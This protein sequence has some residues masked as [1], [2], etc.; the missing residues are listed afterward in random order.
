[1]INLNGLNFDLLDIDEIEDSKN[2]TVDIEVENDHYYILDNNIISH[3][4]ISL[5]ADVTSGIEPLFAKAYKRKD[6]VSERIYVHPKYEEMLLHGKVDG[7]NEDEWFV[8]ALNDLK[9]QDHFEIQV[10]VQKY[11]DGSVSKT[12]NLPTEMTEADLS[13]LLLEYVRDLKGVTVYRDG[14][15]D[16]Q[17]LMK[18]N[19]KE[20]LSYL[21]KGKDIKHTLTTEDVKCASGSCEI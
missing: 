7:E 9:P 14:C 5:L 8:D 2:Y 15:R 18:L 16:G 6:R 12:I 11:V 19:K 1:M 4:T 21:S 13:Q 3:N 20:V 17:P 10:A